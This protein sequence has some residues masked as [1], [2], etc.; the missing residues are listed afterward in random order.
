MRLFLGQ[1]TW[2][3]SFRSTSVVLSGSQICGESG[4]A[5][6]ESPFQ[7]VICCVSNSSL[8]RQSEARKVVSTVFL[9]LPVL[10]MLA[11][12]YAVLLQVISFFGL[13]KF[14]FVIYDLYF[15]T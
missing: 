4:D 15:D 6:Q 5:I 11:D 2:A 1:D 8:S 3:F 7:R 10:S 12:V 9:P 14:H 13:R